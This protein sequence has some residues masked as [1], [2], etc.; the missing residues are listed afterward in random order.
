MPLAIKTTRRDELVE[1]SIFDRGAIKAPNPSSVNSPALKRQFRCGG[2]SK[3]PDLVFSLKPVAVNSRFSSGSSCFFFQAPLSVGFS[4]PSLPYGHPGQIA[5][6]PGARGLG[7][8]L[9]SRV[10]SEKYLLL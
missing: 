3:I 1:N 10:H 9:D 4:P 7:L 8:V 6:L 2:G 5:T